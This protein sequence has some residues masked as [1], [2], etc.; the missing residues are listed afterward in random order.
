MAERRAFAGL[1]LFPT[2]Y[3]YYVTAVLVH[4]SASR[5]FAMPTSTARRPLYQQVR[6]AAF[7]ARRPAENR[8][9]VAIPAGVRSDH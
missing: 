9:T 8:L 3:R 5:P 7:R 1:L 2:D 6:R 4:D